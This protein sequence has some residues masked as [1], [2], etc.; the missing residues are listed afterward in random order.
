MFKK[1]S[2]KVITLLLAA[3]F[4]LST[5]MVAMAQT[6]NTSNNTPK[7]V[8]WIMA[9]GFS[10]DLLTAATIYRINQLYGP[11][12]V[13]DYFFNFMEFPV[14]GLQT[15]W[16]A[17]HFI[18]ESA[19]TAT[20]MFTGV[21]TNHGW[22]AVDPDYNQLTSIATMLQEQHGFQIGLVADVNM[23]HATQGALYAYSS[24]RGATFDIAMAALETGFNFF[25]GSWRPPARAEEIKEIFREHGYTVVY[26]PE[27]IFA[28]DNTVG[29]V[30]AMSPQQAVHP[31]E[32]FMSIPY[33]LDRSEDDM[34]TADFMQ[35]AINTMMNDTGFFI[36]AETGR[37]DW[38]GHDND[39]VAMIHEVF[40]LAD[41]VQVAIDFYRQHPEDTLIIVTADHDAGG[42][43]VGV[44]RET[45]ISSHQLHL[46]LL[47]YQIVSQANFR[48]ILEDELFFLEEEPTFEAAL[49]LIERY[50]GLVS[51]DSPNA[52]YV[53]P[54]RIL[55]EQDLA[56]LL[57]AYT[58]HHR[59]LLDAAEEG[60]GGGVTSSRFWSTE[61][62]M[63]WGTFGSP[64]GIEATRILAYR[65]GIVWTTFEHTAGPV[66]VFAM[67][68]GAEAFGGFSDNTDM[69]F[70]LADVLNVEHDR[71]PVRTNRHDFSPIVLED[72][73]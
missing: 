57:H 7:Y 64:I 68:A 46:H 9:D 60:L 49:E 18:S 55:T 28:L 66:P 20:A 31:R 8:F 44:Q 24:D 56:D 15:T 54:L 40:E 62:R 10:L 63:R 27:E 42:M 70:R 48:F 53:D 34:S 3:V 58:V 67:G 22:M 61:E 19:A 6:P 4:A 50:I 21:K 23:N 72:D 38:A 2:K 35:V 37:M 73:K 26:T 39:A 13:R 51:P 12:E 65:A 36:M 33:R 11:D 32:A 52:E 29:L 1:K 47:S 16:D 5:P 25:G 69:F 30:H 43:T 41:M 45:A 17:Q 71:T 59:I 14:V